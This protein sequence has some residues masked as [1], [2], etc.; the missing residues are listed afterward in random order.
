MQFVFCEQEKAFAWLDCIRNKVKSPLYIG[1]L[2]LEWPW[3]GSE[4]KPTNQPINPQNIRAVV[5]V[6]QDPT[7]SLLPAPSPH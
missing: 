5:L 2:K 1:Q 4:H 6:V 3:Y 7:T